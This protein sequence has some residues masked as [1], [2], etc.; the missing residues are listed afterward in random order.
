M[1]KAI[2]I[3]SDI[4]KTGESVES[5]AGNENKAVKTPKVAKTTKA[6]TTTNK[7]KA[8]KNDKG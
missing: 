3:D 1:S 7:T 4:H 8:K 2:V 6:A 5:A